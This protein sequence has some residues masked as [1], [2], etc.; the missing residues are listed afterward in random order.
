M[1]AIFYHDA[2]QRDAALAAKEA[3]SKQRGGTIHTEIAQAGPFYRAEDYHQKYF[4]R[5]Q[6]QLEQV[7]ETIYPDLIAFTD[8]PAV[9]RVNGYVGGYGSAKQLEQEIALLGLSPEDQ[10]T[11]RSLYGR[12]H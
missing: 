8:S 3:E 7:Y 1:S 10:D 9:T 5:S 12:Y 2:A 11:L 6:R 4:L